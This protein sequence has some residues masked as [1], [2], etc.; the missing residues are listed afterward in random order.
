[1]T[2]TEIMIEP[3]NLALINDIS[4]PTT[5]DDS[6]T[7]SAEYTDLADII[8]HA[9]LNIKTGQHKNFRLQHHERNHKIPGPICD[10]NCNENQHLFTAHSVITG[11]IANVMA[12]QKLNLTS[13]LMN[14]MMYHF[15]VFLCIIHNN[16]EIYPF[17]YLSTFEM[18]SL[19]C[20]DIP[21]QLS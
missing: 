7:N 13:Y 8:R 17:G 16:V 2:D 9:L 1:M 4:I 6:D 14:L 12:H 19:H 20:I 15:T 10:K 3:S 11:Y 5:G 18:L 21:S